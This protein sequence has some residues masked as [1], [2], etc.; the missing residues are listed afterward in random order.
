M[1][2]SATEPSAPHAVQ[3]DALSDPEPPQSP[4]IP[5]G[6]AAHRRSQSDT[7]SHKFKSAPP[8]QLSR[9]HSTTRARLAQPPSVLTPP[10]P[11][12]EIPPP[13]PHKRH[14]SGPPVL[15]RTP[16]T[17][18]SDR[19][20]IASPPQPGTKTFLLPAHARRYDEIVHLRQRLNALE[21]ERQAERADMVDLRSELA[22]YKARM[23]VLRHS[24]D[25]EQARI[26]QAEQRAVDAESRAD[27]A[28]KTTKSLRDRLDKLE[29]ARRREAAEAKQTAADLEKQ[30]RALRDLIF[31]QQHS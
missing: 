22:I 12:D 7:V 6:L 4:R 20:S 13:L 5:I 29:T 17:P 1:D 15:H 3:P 10:I 14:H 21:K 16:T 23:Q 18:S 2:P 19:H 28:E 9:S 11:E 30:L 24:A 8:P 26:A 31:G 25:A 27:E